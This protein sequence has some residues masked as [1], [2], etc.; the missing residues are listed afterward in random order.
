MKNDVDIDAILI[1]NKV[2]CKKGYKY[3]TSHKDDEKVK[4]LSG[5]ERSFD[6]TKCMCFSIQNGELFEKFNKI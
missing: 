2:S 3:F 4:L 5:R 1:S 6:E